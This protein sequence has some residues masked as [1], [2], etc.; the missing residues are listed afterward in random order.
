MATESTEEHEKINALLDIFPCSS[1]DSVAINYL[2]KPGTRLNFF[3]IVAISL[4]R[5]LVQTRPFKL[6]LDPLQQGR[7]FIDLQGFGALYIR[8]LVNPG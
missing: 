3:N 6:R 8:T 4:T 5:G 2:K 7:Y 1:V